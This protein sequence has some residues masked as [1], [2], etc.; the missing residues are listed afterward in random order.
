MKKENGV[1]GTVCALEVLA[2]VMQISTGTVVNTPCV[3]I[4]A[5]NMGCATWKPIVVFVMKAGL[6]IDH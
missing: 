2:H 5:V 1:L 4:I 3:P 6:V